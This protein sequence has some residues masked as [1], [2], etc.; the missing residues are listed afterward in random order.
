M[1]PLGQL[2]VASAIVESIDL[3]FLPTSRRGQSVFYVFDI[4]WLDGKDLRFRPLLDRKRILRSAVPQQPW[5]LLY[6]DHVERRG[7]DF[8]RHVCDVTWKV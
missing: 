4:L 7:I 5:A 6:A 2:P 1:A 3:L 8:F